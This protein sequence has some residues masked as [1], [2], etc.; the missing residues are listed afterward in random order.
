M[1]NTAPGFRDRFKQFK[2]DM[3]D[4]RPALISGAVCALIAVIVLISLG[5]AP[6]VAV[7]YSGVAFFGGYCFGGILFIDH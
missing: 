1:G 6:A 5:H 2:K 4:I 3:K 7:C